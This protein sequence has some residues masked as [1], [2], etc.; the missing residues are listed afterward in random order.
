MQGPAD[1]QRDL[2]SYLQT[3]ASLGGV[4]EREHICIHMT[5]TPY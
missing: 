5:P 3:F 2:G 4:F 1:M